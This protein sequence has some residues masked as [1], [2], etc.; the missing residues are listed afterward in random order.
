MVQHNIS[1]PSYETEASQTTV[2]I[3]IF[4]KDFE[5]EAQAFQSFA[6]GP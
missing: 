3:I 6:I 1:G 5:I 2:Y 4:L